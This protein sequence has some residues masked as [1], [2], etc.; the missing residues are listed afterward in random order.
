MVVER[1]DRHISWRPL[2]LSI[3]NF[4]G[5]KVIYAVFN[6]D[7]GVFLVLHH[8]KGLFNSQIHK[9]FENN[10]KQQNNFQ[11]FEFLIQRDNLFSFYTVIKAS[12]FQQRNYFF[13]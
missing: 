12:F 1:I 11:D 8:F 5:W 9:I 2:F 4:I 6:K 10:G 7:G 3:K 13:F